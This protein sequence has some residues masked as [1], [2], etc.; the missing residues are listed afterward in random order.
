MV[1]RYYLG[2]FVCTNAVFVI[3]IMALTLVPK[4]LRIASGY[5]IFTTIYFLALILSGLVKISTWPAII[6]DHFI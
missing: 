5:A 2:L 3:S 4:E 1:G 6:E